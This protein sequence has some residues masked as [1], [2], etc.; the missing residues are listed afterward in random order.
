MATAV[1]VE[2]RVYFKK[3]GMSSTEWYYVVV[4]AQLSEEDISKEVKKRGYTQIETR[5]YSAAW[6]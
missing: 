3:L 5:Y 6:P 1:A 2:K 4:A